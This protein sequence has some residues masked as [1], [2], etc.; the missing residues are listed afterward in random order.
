MSFIIPHTALKPHIAELTQEEIITILNNIPYIKK[1][2]TSS[3]KGR[4]FECT[5]EN[6]IKNYDIKK[7][8]PHTGDYIISKKEY[9]Q[10][11]IMLEIKNYNYKVPKKE[12]EKFLSDLELNKFAGGI[13]ITKTPVQD[14]EYTTYLFQNNIIIVEYTENTNIEIFCDL[15]WLRLYDRY[16]YKFIDSP[17]KLKNICAI[18]EKKIS[19]LARLKIDTDNMQ[20]SIRR[21]LKSTQITTENIMCDI[22]ETINE[23]TSLFTPV[24]IYNETQECIIPFNYSSAEKEIITALIKTRGTYILAENKTAYEYNFRGEKYLFN[25]LKTKTTLSFKI[26]KFYDEMLGA[27]IKDGYLYIDIKPENMDMIRKFLAI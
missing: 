18:L 9:P 10:I 8:P 15:L 24:S 25:V 1:Q 19:E 11:Q 4:I 27:I 23:I 2:I 14:I 16:N 5:I 7:S 6:S 3:H 26:E 12:Y 22:R 20:K 17:P 13:F 21:Y